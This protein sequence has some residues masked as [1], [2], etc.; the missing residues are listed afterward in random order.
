[1]G[2]TQDIQLVADTISYLAEIG[3]TKV[4]NPTPSR[5]YEGKRGSIANY[6]VVQLGPIRTYQDPTGE[7]HLGVLVSYEASSEAGEDLCDYYTKE[8][9]KV[10]LEH[11]PEYLAQRGYKKHE[12]IQ[13]KIE[14]HRASKTKLVIVGGM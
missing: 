3:I 14:K 4:G 6:S 7:P 12:R 11:L 9:R 5:T 13:D 2:N 1:M 8:I 10:T